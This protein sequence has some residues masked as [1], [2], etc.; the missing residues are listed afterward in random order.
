VRLGKHMLVY[1][2][3]VYIWGVFK[4][5]MVS[6]ATGQY[7]GTLSFLPIKRAFSINRALDNFST[8]GV[9]HFQCARQRC[10]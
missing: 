8:R 4:V 7:G 6:R 1:K 3:G 10:I 9:C 2:N 5:T